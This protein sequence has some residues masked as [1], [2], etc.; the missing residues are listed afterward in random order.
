MKL[1]ITAALSLF[2]LLLVGI[3]AVVFFNSEN[4]VVYE[5]QQFNTRPPTV[6]RSA[7]DLTYSQEVRTLTARTR[8]LEKQLTSQRESAQ[9]QIQ[10]LQ[11]ELQNARQSAQSS[12]GK[13]VSSLSTENSKLREENNRILKNME[14]LKSSLDALKSSGKPATQEELAAM[15]A[16]EIAKHKSEIPV[17]VP[18]SPADVE[19][20]KTDSGQTALTPDNI[21]IPGAKETSS[22][23]AITAAEPKP[24]RVHH[25]P[26][27]SAP[28]TGTV[29]PN[30]DIL[31]QVVGNVSNLFTGSTG[32]NSSNSRTV[33]QGTG[34]VPALSGQRPAVS[35]QTRFPIYTLP[36]TT[37]LNDAVLITPMIGKV[38]IG[39]NVNDPYRFQ[40]EL[41]ETNLAANGHR[42]P[43]VAKVI[44]AGTAFG[45]REQSCVR[46]NIH[47]LT[48]IFRDGRIHT[49][50][51]GSGASNR[52]SGGLAYI[53][54]PWGKPCIRGE[55]INNSVDYLKSRSGAAFL[56]G[57]AAAYGDAQI[58]RQT[59]SNGLR[60]AFVSGNTYQYAAAFGLSNTANE[61]ANYVRERA[62]GAFD[63][64]YVP[65]AQKVQLVV[66][67]QINIDYDTKARKVSFL[68]NNSAVT[69]D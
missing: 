41:G 40:L 11:R 22:G 14:D 56:Q 16:E 48:F 27:G 63:V 20:V 43:G 52:A 65:Q 58:T 49:V 26:Y 24:A 29:T 19:P 18:A 67:Q 15:I 9:A 1:A 69:Y 4:N 44:A 35:K 66:E 33:L 8:Q 45:N 31:D 7:E 23:E 55:Y 53:A 12:L 39:N 37:M 3:A 34:A 25:R 46:G 30:G 47:T 6:E 42:I 68:N 51:S 64:V 2:V 32:S 61:I 57:L 60:E 28:T 21:F 13:E 54:D 50:S 17:T 62:L 59:D 5:A 10:D 38:P 36:V